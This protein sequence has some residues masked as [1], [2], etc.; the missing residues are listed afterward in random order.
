MIKIDKSFKENCLMEKGDPLNLSE[1]E[2]AF[3]HIKICPKCGSGKGFWLGV[4]SDKPYAHCKNCG[5]RFDF[6][7]VYR[8]DDKKKSD[9]MGFFRR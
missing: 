4:K 6:Y 7:E 9:R 2:V 1:I 3:T 8:I 5:A